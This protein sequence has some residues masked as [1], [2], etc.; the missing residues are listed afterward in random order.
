V[1]EFVTHSGCQYARETKGLHPRD[2]PGRAG[3]RARR[4]PQG[5]P[6]TRCEALDETAKYGWINAPRW[7]GNAMEVGPLSRKVPGGVQPEESP[8]IMETTDGVLKQLDVPATAPLGTP[9]RTAAR[10]I[11]SLYCV[12]MQLAQLDQP[13]AD[14]R[15]GDTATAN[16]DKW[17][18]GP[19]PRECKG[20]SFNEAPRGAL[21]PTG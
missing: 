6:G 7:R 9:G 10:A 1:Q 3:L 13:I 20:A 2:G 21:G 16:L 11:D 19:W 14:I 8:W 12:D 17:A 5:P 4:R 18:P 15:A